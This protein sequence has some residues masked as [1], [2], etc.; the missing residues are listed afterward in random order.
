MEYLKPPNWDVALETKKTKAGRNLFPPAPNICSEADIKTGFSA[1]TI[2]DNRNFV[3]L[4]INDLNLMKMTSNYILG[5]GF[6][7]I[8]DCC[9]ESEGHRKLHPTEMRLK[10]A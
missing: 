9:L 6:L 10:W 4:I 3:S 2:W 7:Q 5:G 1:P 8:S